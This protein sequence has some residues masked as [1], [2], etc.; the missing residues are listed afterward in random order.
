MG[1]QIIG[2]CLCKGRVEN[3]KPHPAG[4]QAVEAVSNTCQSCAL[5]VAADRAYGRPKKLA[6]R[7]L[8]VLRSLKDRTWDSADV[9]C[10]PSA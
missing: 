3:R 2:K 1:T 9:P 8:L 4:V 7:S 5:I 6:V 10:I